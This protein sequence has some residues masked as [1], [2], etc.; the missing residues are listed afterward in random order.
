MI[1]VIY[2]Q[3]AAYGPTYRNFS[4]ILDIDPSTASTLRLSY[5]YMIVRIDLERG[6]IE[7]LD[8]KKAA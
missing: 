6:I 3:S 1:F 7:V 8:R 2:R 4:S 5:E